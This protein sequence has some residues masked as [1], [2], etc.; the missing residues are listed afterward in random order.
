MRAERQQAHVGHKRAPIWKHLVED[1]Y[2]K[3][4]R[5]NVPTN[6][7]G[8]SSAGLERRTVNPE[9]A[10]SS[11]VIHPTL[12]RPDTRSQSDF[13][14]VSQHAANAKPRTPRRDAAQ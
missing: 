3:Q 12:S 1:P 4:C 5:H 11:P 8:C 10:G 7:G 6:G 2:D 14:A 9:A 13:R